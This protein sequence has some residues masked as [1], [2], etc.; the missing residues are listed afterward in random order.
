MKR[1]STVVGVVLV[2]LVVL[3]ASTHA[4]AGPEPHGSD[5]CL[6]CALCAWMNAL[7]S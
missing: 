5:S 3:A 6:A 2:A 4:A 1:F 7:V